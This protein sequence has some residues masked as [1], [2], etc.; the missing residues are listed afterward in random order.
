MAQLR[1]A[2]ADWHAPVQEII[3][4]CDK[5]TLWGLYARP[6]LP[7]W[8]DGRAILLGDACHPMLPFMAQGAAMAIEDGYVLAKQLAQKNIRF[9]QALQNYQLARQPRTSMVQKISRDNAYL[10]HAHTRTAR[11]IRRLKFKLAH[12]MPWVLAMVFALYMDKIY[13]KNV[14]RTD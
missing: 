8:C 14:V 11:F 7:H 12:S 1:A 2:F 3:A 10:F 5:C 4:A 6:P 9:T 13:K